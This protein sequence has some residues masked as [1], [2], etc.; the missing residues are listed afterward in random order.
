MTEPS[1]ILIVDD[2]PFNV[3]YLEQELEDLGYE[4]ISAADGQEALDKVKA[5]RPDIVLLDVMMPVMDGF[6]ACRLLKDDDDTR[7]IPVLFMTALD[8]VED[9]VKGIEAGADDFLTKPVDPRELVARIQTALKLKEAME[10]KLGHERRRAEHFAKFVPE[11]VKRLAADDPDAPELSQQV[12]QDVTI[13]QCDISG[14]SRL[15][16]QLS[17]EKLNALV[18]RYFLRLP[19]PHRTAG[20]DINEYAGDGFMAIFQEGDGGP[21]ACRAVAVALELLAVTEELNCDEQE[22]P[23]SVHMGVN[24]GSA[25]VGSSRFE[26]AQGTRWTFT[27]RGPVTNLAGRLRDTAVAGQIVVGPETAA[28]VGDTFRLESLGIKTFKNMEEPVEVHLVMRD[29]GKA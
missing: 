29:E 10:Q 25:L 15:S 3:D 11:P 26:G 24:S 13:L 2:E 22:N 23:L 5:E 4:T 27:A 18:E 1:K 9:R 6:T 20:G 16:E 7:F 14:Y 19:R 28:R 17:P 8:Q 21:H 12:E